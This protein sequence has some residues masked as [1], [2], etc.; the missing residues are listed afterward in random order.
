MPKE[1]S[2]LR[3]RDKLEIKAVGVVEEG[4]VEG[5]LGQV[6]GAGV[7]GAG[8]TGAPGAG[9]AR[10]GG[11]DRG[12]VRVVSLAF[13]TCSPMISPVHSPTTATTPI[14]MINGCLQRGGEEEAPGCLGASV[15][16]SRQICI[17]GSEVLGFSMC[18]LTFLRGFEIK[19]CGGDST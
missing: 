18:R 9:V 6:D 16:S 7:A 2:C 4:S 19:H 11:T 14:A 15:S 8:V 17:A 13:D 1:S 3:S 12:A 5:R 10:A